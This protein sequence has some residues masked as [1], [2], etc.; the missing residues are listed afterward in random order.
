[1]KKSDPA[2]VIPK[3]DAAVV[4]N[5]VPALPI[6]NVLWRE[7][8]GIRA[9]GQLCHDAEN[10]YVRLSAA[11]KEIRAEYTEPLSPVHEDSCLEFFFLPEGAGNYLNFEINPNGCLRVQLGPDRANRVELV[12]NDMRGYFDIRTERTADGWAVSYRIP[13]EFLRLFY[14]AFSFA[15]DLMANLYKCGEKTPRAHYLS[16]APVTL[17]TPDFHRPE[18]FARLRFEE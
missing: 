6:G 10:L 7:D 15:D 12:K 4:W 1:M 18:F 17:D 3:T 5:R 11:E 16:W 13:L 2:F 9:Q 14:P 8:A